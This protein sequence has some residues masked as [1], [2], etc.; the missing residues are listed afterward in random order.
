MRTSPPLGCVAL[1]ALCVAQDSR[2]APP[3]GPIVGGEAGR[4]LAAQ[5]SAHKS[6]WGCVL[7]AKSGKIV[8]A[9]GFGMADRKSEPITPHSQ[10]DVGGLAALFTAV[11]ILD[12]EEQKKLAT[13]DPIGKHLGDV[14]A[15]KQAITIHHLLTHTSGL[16]RDLPFTL[17]Q[18]N[19]RD[20]FVATVMKAPLGHVPGRG[21]LH[22]E[23][24]SCLLAVIVEKAAGQP[25]DRFV[26]QHLLAPAGMRATGFVQDQD[27]DRAA[28]TSRQFDK[29]GEK[30]TIGA[31]D[32]P[33]H[34]RLRGCSGL[35]TS[36]YDLF[37]WD[38]ALR[39]DALLGAA[40]R[41][42]LHE[43]RY[44]DCGYAGF[45]EEVKKV[46]RYRLE[47]QAPGYRALLVRNPAA[48]EL[49]VVLTS[50]EG[51]VTVGGRLKP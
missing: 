14:P 5:V 19:D 36:V 7:V 6:F 10:F 8:L 46:K 13:A 45:I 15:D 12:L 33:R 31:F 49:T 48:N 23:L 39:G 4:R 37:L 40:A 30:V 29:D 20:K 9:Q 47:G 25:Y 17:A 2:P 42:K 24:N 18:A 11:A 27:V 51:D 26:K 28:Q 50:G 3:A 32:G 35:V 1:A 16:P 22:S 34:W 41:K 21:L 38:Q 43:E 44:G